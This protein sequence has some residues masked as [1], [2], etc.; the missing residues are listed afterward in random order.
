VTV[1]FTDI[2][3]STRLGERLDPEPLNGVL[4]EYFR[5]MRGALE[6][7]GGLVEKYIGDAILGVFGIPYLHEDDP[8][9]RYGPRPR[10]AQPSTG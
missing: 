9:A 10:C 5:R 4:T 1:L 6:R 8:C 3:E 2:V 7:H